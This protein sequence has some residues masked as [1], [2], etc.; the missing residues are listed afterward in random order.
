MTKPNRTN[1]PERP[2]DPF[3]FQRQNKKN[4][5]DFIRIKSRESEEERGGQHD[6]G[7]IRAEEKGR[8]GRADHAEEKVE[9]DPERAPGP[10][11][12][13][14]DEPKKPEGE[15]DPPKAECRR[16]KYVGNETPDFPMPDFCR[17]KRE[18]WTET[19]VAD[20]QG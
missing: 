7:K 6:V 8:D 12:T 1:A 13:I 17:V 15:N 19:P 18:A 3:D 20:A 9:R 4:I 5:D 10:L 16:E 2:C 14:T 11:Q